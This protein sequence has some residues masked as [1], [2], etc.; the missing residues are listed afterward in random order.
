LGRITRGLTKLLTIS[1]GDQR[2]D[3]GSA[4]EHVLRAIVAGGQGGERI[5][6]GC[7]GNFV[8]QEIDRAARK[9]GLGGLKACLEAIDA[10]YHELVIN[11][12]PEEIL[13]E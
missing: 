5:L 8:A 4:D 10:T 13:R 1:T 7:G 11:R 6:S 9:A 12:R 2:P 3:P